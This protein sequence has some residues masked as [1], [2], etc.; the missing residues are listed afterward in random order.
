MTDLARVWHYIL[1]YIFLVL[2]TYYIKNSTYEY[3]IID[4][5]RQYSLTLMHRNDVK[6]FAHYFV[7]KQCY[8]NGMC[9]YVS[10]IIL[11][12]CSY[13]Q[14]TAINVLSQWIK[15]VFGDFM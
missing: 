7:M 6:F 9:N 2:K 1:E 3:N 13:H 4:L 14:F 10:I 11:I 5:C 8:V 15:V 12:L